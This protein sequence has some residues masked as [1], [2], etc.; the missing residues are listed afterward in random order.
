M[1][2]QSDLDL[3]LAGKATVQDKPKAEACLQCL[4]P[5]TEKRDVQEAFKVSMKWCNLEP[6]VVAELTTHLCKL[7]AQ[8]MEAQLEA[9][10]AVITH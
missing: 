7:A 5:F 4:M 2:G 6:Q 9:T 10:D 8:L 1:A 3:V